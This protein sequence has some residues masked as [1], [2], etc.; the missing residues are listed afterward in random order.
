MTSRI[1]RKL[2][3]GIQTFR[4]IRE[5]GTT[6]VD[7]CPAASTGG[8][9]GRLGAGSPGT[10]PF[11]PGFGDSEGCEGLSTGS[12]TALQAALDHVFRLLMRCRGPDMPPRRASTRLR[13]VARACTVRFPR[14]CLYGRVSGLAA[15]ALDVEFEDV[16]AVNEAVDGGKGHGV[17]AED[18]A[19]GAERLVGDQ[20]ERAVL[21]ARADEFEEHAGLRI[22][23]GHIGEV[24]EDQEVVLVELADGGFEGEVPAC[25]LELLHQRRRALVEDPEPVLDECEPEGRGQVAL[26]RAP[27]S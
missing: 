24:V 2:P 17:A 8:F 13:P 3:I 20:Q 12:R 18:L 11:R 26:A 6:Y 16:G 9:L 27:A 4:E 14:R 22:L 23:R 21:V 10:E 25:R 1:R 15:V 19:P 7:I 5:G